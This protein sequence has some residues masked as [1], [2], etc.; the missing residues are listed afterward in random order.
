MDDLTIPNDK[1]PDDGVLPIPSGLCRHARD[2]FS[3]ARFA[4]GNPTDGRGSMVDVAAYTQVLDHF[5]SHPECRRMP[6]SIVLS[7]LNDREFKS[8]EDLYH[9][10]RSGPGWGSFS[11]FDGIEK[12]LPGYTSHP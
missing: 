6:Y 9:F 2:G 5:Y 3:K 7:H 12:C 11:G 4:G 10:V 8:G 1:K